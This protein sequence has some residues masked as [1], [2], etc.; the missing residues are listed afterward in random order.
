MAVELLKTLTP[1][2]SESRPILR[3]VKAAV[4]LAKVATDADPV[5]AKDATAALVNLTDEHAIVLQLV[6]G[7]FIPTLVENICVRAPFS[8]CGTIDR[9]SHLL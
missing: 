8:T 4:A 3:N 2:G 6:E 9:F 1:A 5:T 7:G